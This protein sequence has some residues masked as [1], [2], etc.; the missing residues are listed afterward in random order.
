LRIKALASISIQTF[1]HCLATTVVIFM[2]QIDGEKVQ[3]KTK[4]VRTKFSI[5]LCCFG[6]NSQFDAEFN[7]TT[8]ESTVESNEA[9]PACGGGDGCEAQAQQCKEEPPAAAA[10][11]AAAHSIT[12]IVPIP[13]SSAAAA[14]AAT[15]T[16][17]SSTEP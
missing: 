2:D 9:P 7:L 1:F 8:N 11:A 13:E 10:T 14:A 15:T 3:R 12:G 17:P 5:P 4:T 16:A 6:A